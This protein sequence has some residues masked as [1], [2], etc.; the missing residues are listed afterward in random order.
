MGSTPVTNNG[1][2]QRFATG[3]EQ[4]PKRNE[5]AKT[6]TLRNEGGTFTPSNGHKVIR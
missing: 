3:T 5:A 2:V 4:Q 6:K 1:G